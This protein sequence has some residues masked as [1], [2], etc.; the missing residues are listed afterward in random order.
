MDSIAT[1]FE[2]EHKLRTTIKSAMTYPVVVLIMSLA[3]VAIMLIFIVPIFQDMF[4]NLG[5][6]PS[7]CRRCCSSTRPAR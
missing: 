1:N 2:K 5:G 3:A 7:R 4:S 6:E